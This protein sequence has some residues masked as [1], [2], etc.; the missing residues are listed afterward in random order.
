LEEVGAT[1]RR[2]GPRVRLFSLQTRDLIRNRRG[3]REQIRN[4]SDLSSQSSATTL[5]NPNR[6]FLKN[7]SRRGIKPRKYLI[8][9]SMK[10]DGRQLQIVEEPAFRSHK[11]YNGAIRKRRDRLTMGYFDNLENKSLKK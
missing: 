7:E 5:L 8:R 3:E 9:P 4:R 11:S 1:R 6:R 10:S 2:S